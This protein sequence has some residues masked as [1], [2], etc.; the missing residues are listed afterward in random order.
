MYNLLISLA[1][2]ALAFAVAPLAGFPLY[3]GFAPALLVFPVVMFLLTRR[4][5]AQVQAAV[6]PLQAKLAGLQQP[7]SQAEAQRL[8]QEARA[9]LAV[10]RDTFGPWQFLLGRQLDAQIGMLSYMQLNFDEALPQLERAWRDWTATVAAACIHARHGDLAKTWTA[11]S[12]AASYAKKDPSVYIMW[13]TLAQ[14]KG[15]KDEALKALSA[16]LE[17]MPDNG[18][19]RD[20]KNQVAN[21]RKIDVAAFSDL[22]YRFFPEEMAQQYQ[23]RGRRG[24][25]PEGIGMQVRQGP[26]QPRM[27]GK[28]ARRR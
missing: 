15:D 14:R 16:G 18:R 26:P 21:K 27:R 24:P 22:W 19:L 10:V 13:A 6:G 5:S 1:I 17:Q 9:D 2:A 8:L 4:T 28:M 23:V 12:D 25:P 11:F 20:L 7:K 3:A